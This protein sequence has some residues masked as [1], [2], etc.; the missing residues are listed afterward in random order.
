MTPWQAGGRPLVSALLPAHNAAGFIGETLESL[1]AQTWPALEIL[2]DADASTDA[3]PE[4]LAR[5]AARHANL[6]LTLRRENLGWIGSTNAL[7]AGVRGTYLFFAFH[8]DLWEPRFVETMVERLEA[9]PRA[10]PM[11]SPR[12]HARR[13]LARRRGALVRPAPGARDA[14]GPRPWRDPRPRPDPAL[15]SAPR[16]P[17]PQVATTIGMNFSQYRPIPGKI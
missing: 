6:R 10:S 11:S 3:T 16:R 7:M 17:Q 13:C 15:A 1:A 5:F 2:I 9:E 14:L 12:P 4:I 8:D